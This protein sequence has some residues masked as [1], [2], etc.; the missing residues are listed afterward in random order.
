MESFNEVINKELDKFISGIV[1][2]SKLKHPSTVKL[3][4]RI[5]IARLRAYLEIKDI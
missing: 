3:E 1:S 5:F 4:K 2:D